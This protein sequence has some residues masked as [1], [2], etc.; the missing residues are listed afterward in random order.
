VKNPGIQPSLSSGR[1]VH[2]LGVFSFKF[3]HR[4]AAG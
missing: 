4:L 3:L 1:H 2:R